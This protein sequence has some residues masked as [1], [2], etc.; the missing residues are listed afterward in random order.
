MSVVII[1]FPNY[2]IN[3]NGDVTNNKG[4]ILKPWLDNGYKR[5][6]LCNEN[7]KKFFLLHRLIAI[8]FI[9]N[10]NNYETVDHVDRDRLNN[11]I[12]NLRWASYSQQ[13]QN[14]KKK[15][16][17]SSKFKGVSWDKNNCKWRVRI[18]LN[19]KKQHFG[20]FDYEIDAAKKYNAV[21]LHH[22]LQ[23]FYVLN[24]LPKKKIII[25]RK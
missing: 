24:V 19:G 6:G 14:K 20:F 11:N 22:N 17:C 5:I 2:T 12:S 23:E 7:G 9:D 18:T 25:I 3:V 21:V 13:N 16:N 4:L 8:N 10:P 15:K 1:D